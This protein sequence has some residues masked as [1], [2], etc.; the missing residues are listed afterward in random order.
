LLQEKHSEQV[1]TYN[2]W[3]SQRVAGWE[4]PARWRR[5]A[6]SGTAEWHEL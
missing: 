6:D 4:V 5:G 1:R 3:K 2:Q